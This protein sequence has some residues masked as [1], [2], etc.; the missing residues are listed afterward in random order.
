MVCV[1]EQNQKLVVRHSVAYVVFSVT[2]LAEVKQGLGLWIWVV[3]QGFRVNGL[4]GQ[5]TG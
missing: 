2:A 1:A 4:A 3:K 5:N